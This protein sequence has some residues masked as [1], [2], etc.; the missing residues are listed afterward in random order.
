MKG[1]TEVSWLNGASDLMAVTKAI[2]G[3]GSAIQKQDWGS[4]GAN[5]ATIV[6]KGVM[7]AA[8]QNAVLKKALE[9]AGK[10]ALPTPTAIVDAANIAIIAVD[11]LNGFGTP[12]AGSAV[13]TA[14][15]KLA[16]FMKDLDPGC[17]PDARDWSGT[18]ATAY[19]AQV[20]TLKDY[21]QQMKDLDATLKGYLK[22]QGDQIKEAHM[23]IAVNSAV[24]VAAAGIAMAMYLIPVVGPEVSMAWQIVAA[25]AC[26]AAVFALEMI[27]L[28]NSLSVSNNVAVLAQDYLTLGQEMQTK[29]KGSFGKIQGEV[30]TETSSRLSAFKSISN[31]LSDFAS[32]PTVSSLAATAGDKASPEQRAFLDTASEAPATSAPAAAASAVTPMETPAETPT[33]TAAPAAATA[34]TPASMSKMAQASST[35]SNTVSQPVNQVTQ[36]AQQLASTGQGAKAGAAPAEQAAAAEEDAAAAAAPAGAAAGAEG[37]ER[38]PVDVAEAAAETAAPGRERVR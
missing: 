2:Y 13:S 33:E 27:T 17:L 35:L 36:S 8:K 30:A 31:G 23:C 19:T 4:L 26:C 32:A 38:A 9:T 15:D 14:S 22:S 3:G 24:L 28:S 25:F 37:A 20:I 1:N 21:A 12:N 16:L 10:K 29:L 5:A 7:Y 6:G 11:F 34:F 18:A